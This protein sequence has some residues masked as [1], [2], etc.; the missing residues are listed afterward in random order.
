[1]HTV[2]LNLFEPYN[3]SSGIDSLMEYLK[4]NN[5]ALSNKIEL[6][7]LFRIRKLKVQMYFKEKVAEVRTHTSKPSKS[8]LISKKPE[9]P[10]EEDNSASSSKKEEKDLANVDPKLQARREEQCK[11]LEEKLKAYVQEGVTAIELENYG[12]E[13]KNDIKDN[14]VLNFFFNTLNDILI[15]LAKPQTPIEGKKKSKALAKK[16][17]K[18]NT[19][20]KKVASSQRPQASDYQHRIKQD[21]APRMPNEERRQRNGD[22]RVRE[23]FSSTG[24]PLPSQ[25]DMSKYHQ[26]MQDQRDS[27]DRYIKENPEKR[28]KGKMFISV[29]MGGHNKRY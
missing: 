8:K 27:Y 19:A 11:R 9:F 13:L 29:S 5:I 21:L 24:V 2:D 18:A 10:R 6:D 3:S 28:K 16:K 26:Q 20:D 15:N 1:M 23:G 17:N 12:K 25:T 4:A 14:V 22:K 7:V